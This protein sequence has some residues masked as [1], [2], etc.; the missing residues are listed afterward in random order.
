MTNSLL[1]KWKRENLLNASIG[2]VHSNS[3]GMLNFNSNHLLPPKSA[4][5]MHK[6]GVKDTMIVN[7]NQNATAD[8]I[9]DYDYYNTN[10]GFNQ[11]ADMENDSSIF[12][13]LFNCRGF[14]NTENRHELS[15]QQDV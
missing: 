2:R 4:V 12:S 13:R 11:G 14:D 15:I 6:A 9:F 10:Q 1:K 5:R 3:M 8:R 7:H